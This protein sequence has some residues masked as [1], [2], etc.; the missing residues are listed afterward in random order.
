[1]SDRESARLADEYRKDSRLASFS[2][3]A[4]QISDVSI[5]L[6][7][8]ICGTQAK[9]AGPEDLLILIEP[10]AL[11]ELQPHQV[12]VLRMNISAEDLKIYEE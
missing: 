2:A 8:S 6:S 1:M 7:F 11:K 10:S 5:E 9:K 12:T 3:P 4:F